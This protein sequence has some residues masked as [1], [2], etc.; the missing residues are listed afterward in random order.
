MDRKKHFRKS[1]SRK[2]GKSYR[3]LTELPPVEKVELKMK[4]EKQEREEKV[5]EVTIYLEDIYESLE[6]Q[7]IKESLDMTNF[8][9]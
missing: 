5:P 4:V 7:K 6:Y 9:E 2:K 3:R 8:D 1:N